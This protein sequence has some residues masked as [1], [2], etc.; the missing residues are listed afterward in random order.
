M[1]QEKQND[2]IEAFEELIYQMR[3]SDLDELKKDLETIRTELERAQRMRETLAS[4]SK[5]TCCDTCQEA[6]LVSKQALSDAP[7]EGG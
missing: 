5:N 4:I 7:K 1:T 2:A 3:L 6:K